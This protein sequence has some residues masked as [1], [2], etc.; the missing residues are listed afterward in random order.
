MLMNKNAKKGYFGLLKIIYI[1]IVVALIGETN[2]LII[3][4]VEYLLI[5]EY[6]IC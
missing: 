6:T 4:G 1:T 3:D 2:R 5:E